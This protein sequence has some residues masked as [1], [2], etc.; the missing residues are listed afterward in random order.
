MRSAQD[1]KINEAAPTYEGGKVLQRLL[2]FL[3]KRDPELNDEVLIAVPVSQQAHPSFGITAAARAGFS[4]EAPRPQPLSRASEA[5][6]SRLVEARQVHERGEAA[7]QAAAPGA[8]A[9]AS[10]PAWQALGPSNIPNG[11]TYGTNKVDVI[12]RVAAIAIDPHNPQHILCGSAGGGVWES[13]DNGTTWS[14]RMDAM[15]SLAIGAVAFDPQN[16]KTVYAGSGEGN[17]YSQL[18][19]GVYRS[20]DGGT[21]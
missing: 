18:G 1:A 5:Y 7:A 20:N 3:G 6:A 15:P 12:G 9:P 8:A 19:T 11:Q 13:K 14:A 2:Y 4:T 10:P 21:T 17:F 16:S